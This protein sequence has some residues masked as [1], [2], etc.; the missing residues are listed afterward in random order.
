MSKSYW[1]NVLDKRVG[2]RRA[3]A[4]T[5]ATAVGAALLAACDGGDSGDGEITL[6]ADRLTKPEIAPPKQNVV[7]SI[8]AT[9]VVSRRLRTLSHHGFLRTSNGLT[10]VS[11][12]KKSP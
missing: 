9:S 2:R 7:A 5:S 8:R 11:S 3:L 12:S 4:A 1:Q 10:R 6:S